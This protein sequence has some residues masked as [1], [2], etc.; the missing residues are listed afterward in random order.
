MSRPSDVG[1]IKPGMY[2][3]IDGEPCRV[4]SVDKSKPGKAW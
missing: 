3:I 2:V 4:L 1:S